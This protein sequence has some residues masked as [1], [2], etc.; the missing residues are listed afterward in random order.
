MSDIH[1]P[2]QPPAEPAKPKHIPPGERDLPGLWMTHDP[3]VYYDAGNRS[4]YLYCT[5]AVC[6]KSKD[7]LHWESLGKVVADPPEESVAWT[8]SHD[9]WAPDIVKVGKEYRLYCSNSSWGVRQSCIFLAVSDSPEG[10]FIPK[11]CVLKTSD[12]LPVNAIDANIIE[13]ADSGK[14]Y[15]LYG[16]FWGGCHMLLLDKKTGLAAETG[17]GSCIARRPSWMSGAIEGPY[18]VYH[19]VSRYYYL[20][21]SYGSLKSDYNI[22]IGRSRKITGPFYDFHGRDLADG[23]DNDNTSGLMISCGYRWFDGIPYMAPGHN[24]VL[25]NPDGRMF[26]VSHIREMNFTTDH[27]PSTLQIRQLYLTPDE[28]LIAAAQP[29]AGETLQPLSAEDLIGNYERISLMPSVPQGIQC[30]HPFRLMENGRMECC[31]ILGTWQMTGSYT[32]TVQ[33]GNTMETLTASP[34]WDRELNRPTLSLSGLSDRGICS[35]YKKRP[36]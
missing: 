21:V 13:D 9:I 14:Q 2:K 29:Y 25:M 6:K 32:L 4:Y 31:S 1:Y 30:A 7:L 26:L 35:W 28:W 3:A 16:S 10:P 23:T 34:A 12:E 20:F 18:M 36:N 24:S 19:P 8:Q 5:G 33:Y 15:L 27:E 11:A 17:I 22:R